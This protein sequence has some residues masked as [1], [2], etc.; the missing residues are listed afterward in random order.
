MKTAQQWFDAYGVS[1]QNKTN[2]LI[3]FICVPIIMVT[4]VGLI[5]EIP[6][7]FLI[8]HTPSN[9]HPYMGWHTVFIVFA[10]LFY[11]RLSFKLAVGMLI[12]VAF[13]LY[14]I[15]WMNANDLSVL[16]WSLSFFVLAW[17]GQF[18]GHKIEGAKPSFFEDIQFLLIGPIWILNFIYEKLG[19]KL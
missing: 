14:G 9:Y 15:K 2:K 10:L 17:I 12:F 11:A 13:V 7:D 5:S 16:Y 18:I 4:L 1:H 6:A 8:E 3:H 19:V